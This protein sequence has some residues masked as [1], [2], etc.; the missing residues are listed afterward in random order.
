MI[1]KFTKEFVIDTDPDVKKLIFGALPSEGRYF[2]KQCEALGKGHFRVKVQVPK[3][4][5]YYHFKIEGEEENIL[6]DPNNMQDGAKNWHSICRIGTTSFNQIEF[7]LTPSYINQLNKEEIEIKVIVHQAWIENVDLFIVKNGEEIKYNCINHFKGSSKKYFRCVIKKECLKDSEFYFKIYGKSKEYFFC[8]N[9]L[10]DNQKTKLFNFNEVDI[11]YYPAQESGIAYHIFPD[12]YAKRDGK[13]IEGRKYINWGDNPESKAFYGGNFNGIVDKLDYLKDLGIKYLYLTPV[14]FAYSNDRYDCI[15]Y[16]KVDPLLGTEG[17]FQN[18]VNEV[19]KRGMKLVLDI[20]L[21]HCGTEFWMFADVLKNQQDSKY[22]DYYEI[23][24][25]PVKYK[26]FRPNYSCWWDYGNMP[27]F[28]LKNEKVKEYLFDCCKY[29]LKKYSIDGWR[30]DVS[31]ELEHEF[32][33]EFRQQMKNINNKVLIIGENWKDSRTF[34]EGDQ[35]DGVTNYL[36]WWMAFVPFFCEEKIN[37]SGLADNLMNCYFIYPHNRSIN[38]W[39]VISSHDVPRFSGKLKNKEDIK[40]AIALQMFIPGVPVIYYGDEI[41]LQGGDTPDNRKSMKWDVVNDNPEI[42]QWYKE[43]IKIRNNSEAIK[44]GTIFV[45]LADNEREVLV[46]E[47]KHNN[48]SIYCILNFSFNS[49]SLKLSDILPE[50]RYINV[51]NNELFNN[52]INIKNKSSIFLKQ[53]R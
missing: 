12:S 26:E 25:Y 21:N 53:M 24:G 22:K 39:N 51:L 47:R 32:L 37:I 49:I 11:S 7:E 29:W 2:T 3:G 36:I 41:M 1:E 20:V 52:L 19:H 10:L 50:G 33:R 17:E 31:S 46:L 28:N 8:S 34:L 45:T 16:M 18:L 23:Y 38:N 13:K 44:S 15:D 30:I 6:L 9:R 42:L 5:L 35:L 27:Q 14:F 43:I 4:D 40:N 48:E